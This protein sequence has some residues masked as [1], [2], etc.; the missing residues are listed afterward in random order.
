MKKV[1]VVTFHV[2]TTL[3]TIA[4]IQAALRLIDIRL[5]PDPEDPRVLRW[6][7]FDTRGSSETPGTLFKSEIRRRISSDPSVISVEDEEIA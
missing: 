6:Q 1:T 2:L 7:V 4:K 3:D 5:V